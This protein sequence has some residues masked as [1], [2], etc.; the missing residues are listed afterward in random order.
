MAVSFIYVVSLLLEE[1]YR[2]MVEDK[3]GGLFRLAVG[4]MCSFSDKYVASD[5]KSLLNML[6]LYFQIRD[7]FLNVS[8]FVVVAN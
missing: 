8:R 4:L 2:Q 6:S 3:T 7:D 5:F 1:Q